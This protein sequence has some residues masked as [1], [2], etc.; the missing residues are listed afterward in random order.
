MSVI[1]HD[2]SEGHTIAVTQSTRSDI[3]DTVHKNRRVVFSHIVSVVSG[4]GVQI[5]LLGVIEA[6]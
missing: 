1:W 6:L 2:Y 3:R 4:R 5:I